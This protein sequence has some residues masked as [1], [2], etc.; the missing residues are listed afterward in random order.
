MNELYPELAELALEL[1]KDFGRPIDVHFMSERVA[2]PV[3]GTVTGPYT[4]TP[5]QGVVCKAG[6]KLMSDVRMVGNASTLTTDVDVLFASDVQV[7]DSDKL[8]F[9]GIVWAILKI[10]PVNPGGQL[11]LTRV[12]V[13][14]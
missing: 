6:G 8:G 11:L 10:E 12:T 1:I 13:R 3:A 5:F 2:N 4:I 14:R 7:K 9:D